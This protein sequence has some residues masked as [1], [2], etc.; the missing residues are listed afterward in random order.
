MP[1][2]AE[3]P[4]MRDASKIRRRCEQGINEGLN[5][6]YEALNEAQ[7]T[8]ATSIH[9]AYMHWTY[10]NEDAGACFHKETA[11]GNNAG[12]VRLMSKA[13]N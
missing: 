6:L 10:G 5:S 4:R 3:L 11:G 2:Y 12:C 13:Y 1:K 9:L 7:T 8:R